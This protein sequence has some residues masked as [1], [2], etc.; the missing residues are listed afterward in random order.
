MRLKL[1]VGFQ[2]LQWALLG[3]LAHAQA[4]TQPLP[5]LPPPPPPAESAPAPSAAPQ[6]PAAAPEGGAEACVPPCRAGFMCQRGVCISACNPPCP[7]GQQ[8]TAQGEC[9]SPY[10]YPQQ[11]M[12]PP[13]P[14][15]P[16]PPPALLDRPPPPPPPPGSHEHDGFFMRGGFG[17]GFTAT[18]Q[19]P[20][21]ANTSALDSTFTGIALALNVDIGFAPVTNFVLQ[22]RFGF[23]ITPEPRISVDGV[24]DTVSGNFSLGTL[25]IAPGLTYYFM[26]INLYIT[27]AVGLAW[28]TFDSDR[29][30]D[31]DGYDYDDNTDATNP[32]IGLNLDVGKEWWIGRQWGIGVAARMN[33][34]AATGEVVS[35][36]YDYTQWGFAILFSATMQ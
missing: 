35:G 8:C 20:S 23:M 30:Y 12:Y 11:Q 29:V 36:R 22:A 16:P 6:A 31:Y 26:P 5:E 24:D 21:R 2:A 14:M 25:L 28:F 27:G 4:G 15:Y 34:A 19:S 9:I 17:V 13:A 32:G 10:P 7:A 3:A 1:A 33:F 18:E